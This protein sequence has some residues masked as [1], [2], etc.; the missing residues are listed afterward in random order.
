MGG[1]SS[2]P[3]GLAPLPSIAFSISS[4]LASGCPVPWAGVGCGSDSACVF[5]SLLCRHLEQINLPLS[6]LCLSKWFFVC[7]FVFPWFSV[8]DR[9]W[10]C[11]LR[12][13]MILK[14]PCLAC[15]CWDRRPG[16]LV[17]G[18]PHPA[19][20]ETPEAL[21]LQTCIFPTL[22]HSSVQPHPPTQRSLYAD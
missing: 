21:T 16:S 2:T 11:S 17:L 12:L 18:D 13:V 20:V 6:Q 14:C 10:L 3:Q 4:S 7:L 22:L 19:L 1:T 5:L 15:L 9:V 8:Q